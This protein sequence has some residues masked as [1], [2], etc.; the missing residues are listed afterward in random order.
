VTDVVAAQSEA[1][2]TVTVAILTYLRPTLLANLLPLVVAQ[3]PE[4]GP[5]YRCEVL[6]V[7]NDP[8]GSASAVVSAHGGPAVRYVS[9]ATPGIAA[10]RNRALDES[11]G[12][13]VFIDDDELPGE[14][15]LRHLV[16]TWE[17]S[18]PA[19]VSGRVIVE[20][21][22]EPDAWLLG[23]RFFQRR[24]LASGTP[25]TVASTNNLLVDVPQIRAY[26]VRF[27]VDLGLAGGEDTL[28]TRQLHHLGARM[29]WCNES[30]VTDVIPEGR[31]THRW[32]LS[33]AWSHGNSSAV[34]SVRLSSPGLPR[35][36]TRMSVAAGGVLRV[37]KG[38]AVWLGGSLMRSVAHS[39]FGLRTLCRGA[40][41]CA[42]AM[43]WLHL[44]Y[45]RP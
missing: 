12:L 30:V 37:A 11:S 1:S 44:E 32:A 25:I 41:M 26:G 10:A 16:R 45:G 40:G 28:F 3:L 5:D 33:R 31:L 27:A 29:L 15:W 38:G 9:E 2:R 18:R 14:G 20:F 21:A 8:A 6:V 17:R 7:D 23:G 34:V 13:L 4:V 19:I 36:A 42:G 39:A 35:A 22:S 24:A 43:G